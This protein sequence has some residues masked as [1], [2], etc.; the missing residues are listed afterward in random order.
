MML[1]KLGFAGQVRKVM[2]WRTVAGGATLGQKLGKTQLGL[3]Q[4]LDRCW[5]QPTGPAGQLMLNQARI[6]CRRV[7]AGPRH[8]A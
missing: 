1:A 6:S 5:G 2:F 3:V 4:D 8:R 7:W